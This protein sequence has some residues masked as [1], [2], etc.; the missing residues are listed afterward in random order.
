VQNNVI[1][2][3]NQSFITH[4][5]KPDAA[6]E[7][8]V[9]SLQFPFTGTKDRIIPVAHK[10]YDKPENQDTKK[11]PFSDWLKAMKCSQAKAVQAQ[12]GKFSAFQSY[13]FHKE[14]FSDSV[15][16]ST[17]QKPNP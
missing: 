11:N 13:S 6:L 3:R 5:K 9:I 2:I 10:L 7:T 17:A 16:N 8:T 1:Q 14:M 4:G 12:H 15:C